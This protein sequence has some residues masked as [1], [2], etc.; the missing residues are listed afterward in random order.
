MHPKL[1]R[2]LRK[3]FGSPDAVPAACLALLDVVS[4]AY[5]DAD[6]ER[7]L[8]E[9]SLELSSTEMV[10]RFKLA[11][12]NLATANEGARELERSKTALLNVLEDEQLMKQTLKKSEAMLNEMGRMAKVGG[13]EIDVATRKLTWTEEVYRIHEVDMT[14]APTVTKAVAFYAPASRPVI[15]RAVQRAIAYGE[16]FEVELEFITAK[17]NHR[18][19]HAIGKAYQEHGEVKTVSGTFHDVTENRKAG[20][21]IKELDVLRTKFIGVVSHQLR[22]PLSVIRWNLES[23]LSGGLG[24]MPEAQHEFVRITYESDLEIIRRVNDLLT[25]MDIEEGRVSLTREETSLESLWNSVMA[26]W[27]RACDVKELSCTYRAPP[28]PLPGMTVD[29]DKIRSVFTKLMENAVNYTPNK[30]R[31]KARLMQ[32]DG[33]VRFEISDTGVGIPKV[34]QARIFTRFYR[35]SNASTMKPD[36]SGLGLSIAE[37]FVKQHD[38]KIGFTSVEGKGST[39]W[40]EL[41]ITAS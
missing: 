18:W 30:G 11:Q 19:V 16:P 36:A 31:V 22:T 13:W 25:V 15:E 3:H 41:P 17:G 20:D 37:Y 7:L 39:F 27:K 21:R 33:R 1:E 4:K 14:Y 23:L 38:G 8:L 2:Q 32:T 34:E 40:F 5:Q 26:D 24:P 12:Q 9:R 6:D 35:A 10:E 28:T 29:A